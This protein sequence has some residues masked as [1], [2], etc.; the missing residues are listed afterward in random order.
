METRANYVTIGIFT[1]AVIVGIF[2][3]VWW[4]QR[5]GTGEEQVEYEI[6]FES[7]VSGLRQGAVVN[8]NGIRVGDVKNLG[9]VFNDPQAVIAIIQVR[10][11]TPIRTDTK[12]SLEYQGLTGIANIAL[13]GGA[14]NAP[15]LMEQMAEKDK[16]KKLPRLVAAKTTDAFTAATQLMTRLNDL[17]AANEMRFNEI[18]TNLA[19]VS[20]ILAQRGD[21]TLTEVQ[22]AAEAIR[23]LAD[24][25]NNQTGPALNEYRQLASDARRAVSEIDRLIRN[26][27]RNP[28]QFLFNNGGTVPQ[29][30][31]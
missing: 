27:E 23:K 29:Y 8:F 11:S 22:N 28:R 7:P 17:V 12:V 1:L 26:I 9:L 31:R 4:F 15:M 3:F 13:T 20:R 21:M 10:K 14:S 5:L 30:N 24:S 25:V 16:G 6:Y 18:T 19:E 2:A